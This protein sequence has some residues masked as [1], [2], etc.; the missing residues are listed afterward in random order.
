M[1][2]NAKKKIHK[3]LQN[4]KNI[5]NFEEKNPKSSKNHFFSSSKSEFFGE[6]N[7]EKRERKSSLFLNMRNTR[8][9][10]SSPVQPNPEK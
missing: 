8:F 9:D 2:E 3:T 7:S 5:E 10:Q 6:K 4:P 1:K